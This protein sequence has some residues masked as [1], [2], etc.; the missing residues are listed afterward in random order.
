MKYSQPIKLTWN[1]TVISFGPVPLPFTF[2]GC[3]TGFAIGVL[4]HFSV[5]TLGLLLPYLFSAITLILYST[6]GD[7]VTI[8]LSRYFS[9]LFEILITCQVSEL[10]CQVSELTLVRASI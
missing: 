2:V 9:V 6:H 3:F 7:N 4:I 8:S 5:S 1:V 10:T